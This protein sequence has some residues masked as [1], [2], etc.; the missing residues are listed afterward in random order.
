MQCVGACKKKFVFCFKLFVREKNML[1]Y[2]NSENSVSY[3]IYS[4]DVHVFQKFHV[5]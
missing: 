4:S 1:N 3:V 2:E 5:K